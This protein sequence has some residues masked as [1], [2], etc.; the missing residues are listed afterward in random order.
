MA[1]PSLRLPP[2]SSSFAMDSV[3]F[4]AEIRDDIVAS[5]R[6]EREVTSIFRGEEERRHRGERGDGRVGGE[7]GGDR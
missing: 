5:P 2:A 4:R 3:A 7:R 6:E 1:S